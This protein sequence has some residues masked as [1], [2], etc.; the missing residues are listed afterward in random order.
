M[1]WGI[2]VYLWITDRNLCKQDRLGRPGVSGSSVRLPRFES[3]ALLLTKHEILGHKSDL[4]TH[5]SFLTC[6]VWLQHFLSHWV[7]GRSKWLN[8]INYL[9]QWLTGGKTLN[10]YY[11]FKLNKENS[12]V[13]RFYFN[14]LIF[15]YSWL[16]KSIVLNMIY[17]NAIKE[18]SL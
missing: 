15:S 8:S 2:W 1:I 18:C 9:V 3:T 16:N 13:S 14:F 5:I 4:S 7:I 12:K 11:F 17:L 10:K 6:V